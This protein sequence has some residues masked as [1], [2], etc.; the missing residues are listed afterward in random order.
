MAVTIEQI[1]ELREATGVSMQACKAALEEAG[2]DFEKAVDHLRKKG[3]AKAADRVGRSSSQGAVVVKSSGGK[4]AMVKLLCETDFVSR[5]DDFVNYATEIADGLLEG[6]YSDSE[7]AVPG[8]AEAGMKLGENVQVGEMALVE[9]P[10]VGAYIHSNKQIGVLIALDGGS[11]ELA[12]DIA[13][14]AA[15]TNP[16]VLSPEEVSDELLQR[17]KAIWAE[18]LAAE[19]KPQEMV[20]K[21]MMGKERKFREENALVKQQFVKNPEHTIEQLLATAG[22]NIV[23]FVRFSV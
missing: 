6:K 4:T 9:A 19:G 22:A 12:K 15:A 3:E 10:V 8:L 18:Q 13:M 7:K 21:I 1:K 11:E 2:G 23:K 20:E 16:S 17:E 14:H 5:G